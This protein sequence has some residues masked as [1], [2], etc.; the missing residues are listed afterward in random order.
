VGVIDIIFDSGGPVVLPC[1]N[2]EV[3][4]MQINRVCEWFLLVDLIED[5]L[6]HGRDRTMAY[7]KGVRK[8]D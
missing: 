4:G 8:G 7:S 6:W 5:V 1:G 3:P 2:G